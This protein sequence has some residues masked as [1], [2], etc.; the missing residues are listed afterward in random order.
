MDEN[1]FIDKANT[2]LDAL[3]E[4]LEA[5]G[6]DVEQEDGVVTVTLD[7]GKQFIINRHLPMKQLWLS[8]P[9]SG[10]SHYTYHAEDDVWRNTRPP[11]DTL[12]ERLLKELEDNP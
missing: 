9:F 5:Q 2:L 3:C 6:I 4:T 7:N 1:T 10:A 12:K 11:N 8:S